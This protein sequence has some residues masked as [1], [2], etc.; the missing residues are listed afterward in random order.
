MPRLQKNYIIACLKAVFGLQNSKQI[1]YVKNL[2]G[3]LFE[4]LTLPQHS[5][6]QQMR[7]LS[8]D[9]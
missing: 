5:T 3:L 2:I 8:V 9:F 6:S 7:D 1:I 4:V